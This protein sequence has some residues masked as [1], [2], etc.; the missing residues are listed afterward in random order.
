MAIKP[1]TY[2]EGDKLV[3]DVYTDSDYDPQGTPSAKEECPIAG[4]CRGTEWNFFGDG[5]Y[6]NWQQGSD[7]SAFR[8][9][10]HI[11]AEVMAPYRTDGAGNPVT[12]TEI[13]LSAAMYI[14]DTIRRADAYFDNIK[15]VDST[16][17]VKQTIFDSSTD[18]SAVTFQLVESK[19]AKAHGAQVEKGTGTEAGIPHSQRSI[20]RPI[21]VWF[22]RDPARIWEPRFPPT[23]LR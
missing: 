8:T 5:L 13:S 1:Y 16:G 22:E 4:I 3:F 18:A 9:W 7:G 10:K 23:N 19:S 17:A 20:R 11:E 6:V 21:H 15:I 14:Q 2:A 12:L